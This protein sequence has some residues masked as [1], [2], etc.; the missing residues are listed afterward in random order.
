MTSSQAM[1]MQPRLRRSL[2][3]RM[4]RP[5]KLLGGA[6][7]LVILLAGVLYAYRSMMLAEGRTPEGYKLLTAAPAA[8]FE[9]SGLPQ[10][11]I[12]ANTASQGLAIDFGYVVGGIPYSYSLTLRFEGS[13]AGRATV[14]ARHATR[15]ASVET[16]A[17]RRWDAPRR[18]FA[19]AL[20]DRF[21]LEPAVPALC[22]KTVIGGDSAP[23]DLRDASLCVAQMDATGACHPETLAC[24]TI[25]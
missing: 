9:P 19:V 7:A 16:P 15:E 21:D 4:S 20:Q 18:A 24:G 22:I 1:F 11:P 8:G 17:V 25:R 23:L 10:R 14:T 12:L 3:A 5:L 6:L 13:D 2:K